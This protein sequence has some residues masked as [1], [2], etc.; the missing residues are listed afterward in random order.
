MVKNLGVGI[1]ILSLIL[2]II[3]YADDLTLIVDNEVN[4][5]K[6]IN[7]GDQS[8]LDDIKFNAKKSSIMIFNNFD[9]MNYD[10]KMYGSSIQNVKEAR[11]LGYQLST[12]SINISNNEVIYP[13]LD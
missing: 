7:A 3:M 4:L 5:Q 1:L 8:E 13:W 10:F 9:K 6:Q 2:G 11:Y 12:E